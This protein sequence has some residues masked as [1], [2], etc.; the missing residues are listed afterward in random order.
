MAQGLP[1]WDPPIGCSDQVF[2]DFLSTLKP[3]ERVVECG[4]VAMVGQQ[5]TII[6]SRGHPGNVMVEWDAEFPVGCKFR[7]GVTKGMRRLSLH[8][9]PEMVGKSWR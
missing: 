1:F 3:G 7:S 6:V 5:G 8:S 2:Q 9:T 4:P